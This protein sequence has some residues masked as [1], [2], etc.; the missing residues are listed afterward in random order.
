MY[1]VATVPEAAELRAAGVRKPLL[2]L[3]NALPAHAETIIDYQLTPSVYEPMLCNALSHAA[4]AKGTS[5]NVHLDVD[6]GMNRGGI[7]YTEAVDFIKLLTSLE[8]I[9]IEGIFT[10]FAT[11][12]EADKVHT[13]LQLERFKSVL[14]TLSKLQSSSP[15]CPCCQ[16]CSCINASR[17]SFWRSPCGLEFIRRLPVV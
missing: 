7:W 3:F 16:Q 10:H 4:Q 12:D 11:A 13:R 15:N 5:V 2:V 8:G 6:T 14:S 1:A 17:I 9:E